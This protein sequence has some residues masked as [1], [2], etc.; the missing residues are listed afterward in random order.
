MKPMGAGGKAGLVGGL[1]GNGTSVPVDVLSYPGGAG[2][3]TP[4][5]CEP[6]ATGMEV[7]AF[8]N[9]IDD[10]SFGASLDPKLEDVAACSLSSS[11][12]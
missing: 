12:L 5:F 4:T 11:E 10:R 8:L 3:S 6:V 2:S 1:G 9:G 7:G